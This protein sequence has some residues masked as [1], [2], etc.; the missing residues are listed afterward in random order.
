MDG[1]LVEG[2]GK[3]GSES[4]DLGPFTKLRISGGLKAVLT[5]GPFGKVTVKADDNLL[6]QIK[7][8]IDRGTLVI[9]IDGSVTTRN[10]MVVEATLPAIDEISA[11]GAASVMAQDFTL[12]QVNI[13]TDGAASVVIQG[14]TKK[15]FV[16]ATGSS[17]VR[18]DLAGGDMNAEITGAS[19]LT[20]GGTARKAS[21]RVT[22]AS[23]FDAP[24]LIIEGGKLV[25]SGASNAKI[26]ERS[27]WS[28]ETSGASTVR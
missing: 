12:E 11:L 23:S 14:T 2:S 22:G 13:N 17:K 5:N 28:V 26:K 24:E 27:Q 15:A 8:K 19:R 6:P 7:T 18:L 25:V 3:A 20:V 21:V 10:D 16:K 4:R 9:T 1:P